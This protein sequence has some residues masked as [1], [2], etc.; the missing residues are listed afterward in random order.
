MAGG[1][2]SHLT[3]TNESGRPHAQMQGRQYILPDADRGL[4]RPETETGFGPKTQPGSL[5]VTCRSALQTG[6]EAIGGF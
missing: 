2:V 1:G 4:A 5:Y 6:A 3:T